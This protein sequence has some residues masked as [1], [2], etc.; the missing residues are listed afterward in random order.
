[1][2]SLLNRL[3]QLLSWVFAIILAIPALSAAAQNPVIR[4]QY[5]ADPTARV[6]GDRVYLYPSHDIISP[7]APEKR[8]F[9]MADYHVFSSTDLTD[10]TD[11]GVILDQK[12]VAWANPEGYAMWAPDCV[13]HHGRY[14][15][16]FPSG[17]KSELGFGIGIATAPSPI[18]PFIPAA[19]PLDGVR[20]IDPCMLQTTQG[21][22]YLFWAGNGG[23]TVARMDDNYQRIAAAPQV[24][25]GLPEGFKEGPFAFERNGLYYLT[26]P[27]VRQKDGTETLAYAMS[28]K[29]EGPYTFKGIIMDEWADKCWTNHHSIMQ[30]RGQWYLFYHHND[31]SPSFDKCRSVRIDSLSFRPDG[32]IVKVEPTLR[33]VG[34]TYARRHIEIDRYS[35]ISSTGAQAMLLDSLQPFRGWALRLN[36][37]GWARY[38]RVAFRPGLCRLTLRARAQK[39]ST[40]AVTI[41]S[42]CVAR[43]NIAP[44]DSFSEQTVSINPVAA[45]TYDIKAQLEKG[46]NA[47]VDWI[48]FE[49]KPIPPYTQGGMQTGRYRNYFAEMGHTPDEIDRRVDSVFQ[50]V[51]FG[52][53]RVYFEIGDTLGYISDLKNHDVRTEG[54]SYGMMI[55]VEMNRKDIF[56]RLWRWA[57]RYMLIRQGPMAGYYAWSCKTDGTHNAEGPAS[58]GELY[59]ITSLIFAS[60][61]WGNHSGIDY[62]AE[63]QRLLRLAREGNTKNGEHALINAKHRLITFTP[64]GF[65][66]RFT[67]PSYHVP[68]FYEVW[69]RWAA[70]GHADYYRACADSSRQFLHR[71]VDPSTALS[72]DFT[73]YDGRPLTLPGNQPMKGNRDFRYDS[74]RVPMN[75]ALDYSWACADSTWQRHYANTLQDFFFN[76]GLDAYIDQYRTDGMP[77]ENPYQGGGKPGL[78]HS[79]GLVS[80]L[81]A[82]SLAADHTK[83]RDFAARLWQSTNTPFADGYFDAYYDGLLRL[84]A[85]L[86]LSGKYR[87]ITPDPS[88]LSGSSPTARAIKSNDKTPSSATCLPEAQRATKAIINQR[89][90]TK[91]LR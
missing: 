33:G 79:V 10:W 51:F 8:W 81:A 6:F 19:R 9:A 49:G 88:L 59:M 82:A 48:S 30:Y 34:L 55:A 16:F 28:Q 36:R 62:L 83:A 32:T 69:A 1:M 58:D 4:D 42:Q 89:V 47:D 86:H 77:A 73:T 78:R 70:D 7:V 40:V 71:C 14:Y 35:S 31:Y 63:A 27:W 64:G 13:E 66:A 91:T 39:P 50:E 25:Q 56:D 75:I 20:G 41:G 43:L 38:N 23:I 68:A 57:Q 85:F 29:P 74:W 21:E 44:C 72:P 61:R 15:L 11:H 52:P 17:M 53:R 54:M 5:A 26:F 84:F 3:S 80:T 76:K 12:Q 37:Q 60:N 45:G 46:S 18:G 65:G 2:T 22:S 67:D 90:T 24:V 87:V